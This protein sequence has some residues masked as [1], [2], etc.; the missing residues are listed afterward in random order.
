MALVEKALLFIWA[1]LKSNEYQILVGANSFRVVS[2][3]FWIKLQAM[4]TPTCQGV[5]HLGT[6]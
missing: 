6:A 4:L 2:E 3:G 5:P 1:T